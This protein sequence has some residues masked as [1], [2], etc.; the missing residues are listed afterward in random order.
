LHRLTVRVTTE[1]DWQYYAS[2]QSA[3]VLALGLVLDAGFLEDVVDG[4]QGG[5]E[6]GL[7]VG[8]RLCEQSDGNAS[9]EVE[10]VA[11]VDKVVIATLL[12]V[13]V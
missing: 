11:L 9:E 7:S 8:L 10:E 13:E 12:I 6:E 5:F 4:L 2:E 1:R 3:E